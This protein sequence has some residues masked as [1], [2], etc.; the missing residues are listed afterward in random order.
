MRRRDLIQ[1]I[2]GLAAAWPLVARAQQSAG[3]MRRIGALILNSKDDPRSRS[4]VAVLQE[5]LDKLG[6]TV[7]DNLQI[8]YRWS[9]SG[10]D[11]ARIATGEL[12]ALFPDLI[13]AHSVS[14]VR[15]AQ[16]ATRTIPVVFTA[17]SEPVTQG[18]VASL[19]H[20]GANITGFTNL[21]PSVGSKWLEL[22]KAIAPRVTRVG[23]MFNPTSSP[24]TPLFSHAVEAAAPDFGMETT[25]LEVH[26][27]ADIEAAMT[28]LSREP[29]GGLILPP[30]TFT[31]F[32][33]KLIAALA[34]RYNLP[35]MFA[36][37]YFVDAGGLISYGPDVV[38]QF[39]RAASYIDRILRGEKPADL[40]VQQPSKFEF[41][42]N[43]KAAKALGLTVPYS[44]QSLAD[45]VIE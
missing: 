22:L 5:G 30:D 40:P 23:L 14:A 4:I 13:V 1:G 25:E 26:D 44:L 3:R 31:S 27:P 29:G 24:V 2:A 17:V 36:F 28:K 33:Y 45:E 11:S 39:R 37:R 34:A 18:F 16:Q 42:I 43:L 15:A 32:H 35:A 10:P 38:D 6:W 20:P 19:A 41:V 9:I 21:E 7:G 8:D 12:L